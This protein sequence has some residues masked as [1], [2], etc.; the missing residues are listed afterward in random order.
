MQN[1]STTAK[2]VIMASWREG[3]KK[4]YCTYLTKWKQFC[5]E[6]NIN[7]L[8]AEVEQGIDFL[9]YLFEQ[10]LSYSAINS[11]RSA[12]SAL[13]TPKDGMAFGEHRLVCRFLKGV[14]EI[15]PSLPKYMEIWDVEQVLTYLRSLN[16]ELSLKQL[17][18]KLVMLL[19]ILTGQRCQTLHKLDLKLMQRLPEKFIFT[20]GAKLKHTRPG[21]HQK[22]IELLSYTDKDLCVVHH[23]EE[24][25]RRTATIRK[26]KSQLL[27]SYIKPHNPVSKD[28]IARWVKGVLKDADINTNNYSSHSSRAAATSYGF[29]KGVKLTEI[30]QAAGRCNAQTFA[31]YYHKPIER[32][33]L[34]SHIMQAFQAN[35]EPDQA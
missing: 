30:L 11:A 5:D 15:K 32:D 31:S 27:I 20:I 4:Q 8:D 17:T 9:A 28:T 6:R 2:E 1:I 23:L 25:I 14:F 13:L 3:T 35:S 16:F 7:W 24:Y 10:K 22:P 33:T 21:T 19:A 34:G 12:L 26:D 29:A 18:H